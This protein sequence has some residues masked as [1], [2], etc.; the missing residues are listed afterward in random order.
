M[1]SV[2]AAYISHVMKN[3][4]MTVHIAVWDKIASGREQLF[5]K[6]LGWA[7][8][9]YNVHRMTTFIPPYQQG[10]IRFT[11]RMG[12]KQEGVMREGVLYKDQWWPLYTFGLLRSELEEKLNNE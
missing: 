3:F 4:D 10:T 5:W 11:G 8:E 1:Q 9:R 2:G 7:A 12:F 6:V